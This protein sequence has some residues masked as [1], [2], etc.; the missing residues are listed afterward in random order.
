[1]NERRI[2][3][4]EEI[5]CGAV[6]FTRDSGEI[7]YLI[8]KQ[9]GGH[10]GFPKG[11]MEGDE[12]EH[13]TAKREVKEEVGITVTDFV[14][15]FKTSDEYI[16]PH[17]RG[18]KKKVILFLAEYS[19]QRIVIQKKE[20]FGAALYPYDEAMKLLSFDGSRRMLREAHEF[21]KKM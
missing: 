13:E 11:H 9:R 7:K 15:G 1:M 14:E 21:L 17:K 16:L 10:Y 4:R 19:G 3:M 8:I 2:K 5:S 6:V 18:A 12:T 20:L